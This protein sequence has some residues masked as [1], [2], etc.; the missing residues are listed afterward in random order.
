MKLKLCLYFR[1]INQKLSNEK[2]CIHRERKYINVF[3][4]QQIKVKVLLPL[5]GGSRAEHTTHGSTD[6]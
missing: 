5:L 1:Q 2:H 4:G 6:R 3:T